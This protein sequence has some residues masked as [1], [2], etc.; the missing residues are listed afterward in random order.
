MGEGESW[1]RCVR[2]RERERVGGGAC[3]GHGESCEVARGRDEMWAWVRER[4]GVCGLGRGRELG[5]G[6][7]L[8]V[9]RRQRR[10]ETP[11]PRP[12]R[13]GR[14]CFHRMG[15]GRG[16]GAPGSERTRSVQAG[17]RQRPLHLGAHTPY[18][19]LLSLSPFSE[20]PRVVELVVSVNAGPAMPAMALDVRVSLWAIPGRPP[21]LGRAP[22]P[23]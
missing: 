23:H 22:R 15:G 10:R 3:V 13:A 19:T 6:R 20:A 21:T 16:G 11:C 1:R 2:V 5:E 7:G 9:S 18:L 8:G 12:G 4:V 17:Q 14:T